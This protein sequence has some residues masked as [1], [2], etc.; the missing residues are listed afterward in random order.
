MKKLFVFLLLSGS[1]YSQNPSYRQNPDQILN[2]VN[3]SNRLYYFLDGEREFEFAPRKKRIALH[4]TKVT[5]TF[6]SKKGKK[7]VSELEFNPKGRLIH[8]KNQT[9]KF[10]YKASFLSDTLEVYSSSTSRKQTTEMKREFTNGLKTQEEKI[11]NG[12]RD[13]RLEISYNT[14]GKISE[15]RVLRKNKRYKMCYEYNTEGKLAKNTYFK[16]DKLIKSWNY[17]CK[18]EGALEASNKNEMI[19]SK[20]EYRQE[21]SDGSYIVYE[22]TLM[23]GKP[24]L[25]EKKFTRDS[26]LYETNDYVRDSIRTKSW[27]KNG[28]WDNTVYYRKGNIRYQTK[29]KRNAKGQLLEYQYFRK[30]GLSSSFKNT[31][32]ADGNCILQERFTPRQE[33]PTYILKLTFNAN[34]TMQSEEVYNKGKLAYQQFYAYTY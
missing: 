1:C 34:G 21:S 12:K 10:E 27:Y 31:Y 28:D 13:Y 4:I 16:N 8:S 9:G 14:S 17:E 24:Y 25:H 26:V 32:D 6:V 23:H 18:P 3:R 15:S 7:N 29:Y 19:S 11:K 5:R 22:R 20:C 33:K 2:E 30:N